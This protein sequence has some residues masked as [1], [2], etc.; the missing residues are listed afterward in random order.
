MENLAIQDTQLSASSEVFLYEVGKARLRNT[1]G[2]WKAAK[3]DEKSW[4]QI[5]FKT[6]VTVKVYLLFFIL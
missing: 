5:D 6:N 3:K 1:D 2:G 4:F